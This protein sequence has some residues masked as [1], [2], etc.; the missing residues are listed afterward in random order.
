VWGFSLLLLG[1]PTSTVRA[2]PVAVAG[3]FNVTTALPLLDV[4]CTLVAVT[5]TVDGAG[6]GVL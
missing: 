2:G 3:G 4:S 1:V 6:K 5:V